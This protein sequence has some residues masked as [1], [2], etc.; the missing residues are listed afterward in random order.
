MKNY[1]T[2]SIKFTD[3]SMSGADILKNVISVR[4]GY[5]EY[6]GVELG[7]EPQDKV[8]KIYRSPETVE[9]ISSMLKDLPVTDEHVEL[10]DT[11]EKD[12]ILGKIEKSEVIENPS[13]TNDSTIALQNVI[14]A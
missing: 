7:L 10:E 9:Q 4:D 1:F 13:K 6:L 5:Q 8:F 14:N 2:Q 3:K 12:L 11:I